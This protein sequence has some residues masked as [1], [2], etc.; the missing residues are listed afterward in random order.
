[1]TDVLLKHVAMFMDVVALVL[2][3]IVLVDMY[4]KAPILEQ[5]REHVNTTRRRARPV[6]LGN[7]NRPARASLSSIIPLNVYCLTFFF[8]DAKFTNILHF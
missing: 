8:Q 1:M 5:S 6:T 7:L 3:N 2:T 4:R